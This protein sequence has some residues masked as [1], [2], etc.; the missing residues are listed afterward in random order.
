MIAI[1]FT[2]LAGRYHAT[3]WG[4]HVNEGAV[5]WPPSPWRILRALVAVWK[6]TVPE[7][8]REQVEPILRALVVPGMRLGQRGIQVVRYAL[9][10]AVLPLVTE[11]LP[12]AEAARGALMGIHGRLTESGGVRGRSTILSGKDEQSRPLAHHRH[13]YYLP[14]DEDGD[15]RLDHL[16]VYPAGGVGAEERRALDRLR[17][18]RTGREGE[19]HHPLR[20]LLLGMAMSEEYSPGPLQASAVW[21]SAT[22]YVATR[23]AKTT[24]RNRID[25]ASPEARAAAMF[26]TRADSC[27]RVCR[28]L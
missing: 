5:E 11:T 8:A 20:L 23:Y 14:T 10:S 27:C 19:E 17:E 15:G 4:R 16:T 12:V 21:T 25:L 22:P 6:R 24:G 3:P 9:D 7:L 18:L 26:E 1:S 2:F 28:T 13:A